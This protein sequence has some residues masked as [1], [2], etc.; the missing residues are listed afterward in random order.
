MIIIL[1]LCLSREVSTES[2]VTTLSSATRVL[3]S[4]LK[5]MSKKFQNSGLLNL[6][7][8]GILTLVKF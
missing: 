7:L 8:P 3:V 4:D 6:I 2:L 1:T 5:R